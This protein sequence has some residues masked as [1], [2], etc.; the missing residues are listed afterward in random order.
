[1]SGC[2]LACGNF[3]EVEAHRLRNVS[4]KI[5]AVVAKTDL[6]ESLQSKLPN[7]LSHYLRLQKALLGNTLANRAVDDLRNLSFYYIYSLYC[8]D[9]L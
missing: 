9:K 7:L 2:K 3:K 8:L 4:L 6:R 5:L 1:M